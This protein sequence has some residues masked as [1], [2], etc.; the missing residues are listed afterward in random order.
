[1]HNP[2]NSYYNLYRDRACNDPIYITELSEP[3]SRITLGP[4]NTA[5]YK[6]EQEMNFPA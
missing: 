2:A 4:N 6:I 1:M 5:Y 3:L